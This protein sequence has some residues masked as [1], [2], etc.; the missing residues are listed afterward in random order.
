MEPGL[1]RDR[2]EAGRRLAEKLAHYAN[3][4]DVLVLALPRGGVP[5]AYEVARALSAPL[6]VFVVRKLGVPGYEELA[7]GA[8][9]TG[10]VRVLNDNIV[11]G[12]HI[13]DYLIDAVANRELE[14][15]RR[16][17]RLYRGGRPPPDVRGRTVIL[18]DDGLATGATM[19]AGIK[20]L[21][22]LEPAGIVVAVPTASPDTCEAL[23]AEVD[24]VICAI[25]PEPFEAV[26]RWYED[27][28]QTSDD[29]VRDLLARRQQPEEQQA[30]PSTTDTTLIEA[31]RAGA[32]PL[33]GA[34]QDYDPVMDL[35]GDARFALLGES[36]HG[37]HEFYRE[38]AQI[39]KRLIEERG[40]TAVAVEA[41][42]PDAWRVNR[43]VRRVSDEVDAV[44]ALTDFRRFPTWMW[45]NTEVVEWLRA[46]NDALAPGAP[47][48]GFY[49]LDL[50]SL[51]ASM[52][53]VL[54]F[55]EKVDPEGAR[56]ARKRYACFDH[57]GEDTQVYGFV[58]DTGLTAS[59]EEEVVSQ[60][61]EL[62]RRTTEYARRDGRVAEDGVFDAEQ[63]ARLVKNAEAYYRSMFLEEVSSWNLRDRHMAETLE[64]LVAH[65]E[66]GGGRAKVAVWA[67]NSHLGDARAT[68][69]GRRGE[70]NLGQL[71]RERY[72]RDAVLIG[73][74][75]HHG[76]V[77]AAS[78]WGAPAERKRV[79]PGMA[80]SYEALFHAARPDRFLLTWREG[81][82]ATEGLRD[83]Q[84]ERAIEVI[85][86]PET[87]RISHY[88]NAA[89]GPVRRR[90]PLRRDA[91][92]QAARVHRRVGGGRAA[93][94]VPLRGVG[95]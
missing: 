48:V 95:D 58:A 66:R 8:V 17:E 19:L 30:E 71:V 3:R 10:G 23:R 94:D 82:P 33:T 77:T 84:L 25:T 53:A 85:Y 36:S 54:Q 21:R 49:G 63:N 74:T 56:Q 32:H 76:T 70:L 34:A 37:T 47:K 87:E 7:M 92:G 81:D 43:Y 59:C 18:V 57:F 67:H 79:R 2:S 12:L 55:L 46:Y 90:A 11:A 16:R 28:S 6:D 45:R 52:K 15:L 1:F 44:E 62:R 5:V 93:A 31:V 39:T 22:Q 73:F 41:D 20:A 60:L 29:E 40:F 4:P 27:F 50:Y 24:E 69:T 68:E 75:T 51:R 26:G 86:R 13:P 72:G 14:E 9:A 38:R 83:P 91:G 64:A 42:W 80:G 61:V 35:V 88:F 65:L 78:E 89:A